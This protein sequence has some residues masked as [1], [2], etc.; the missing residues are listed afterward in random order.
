M[1]VNGVELQCRLSVYRPGP[2][3]ACLEC[4]WGEDDYRLREQHFPCAQ[5]SEIGVLDQPAL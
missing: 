2:R 3:S 5:R 4:G 1:A